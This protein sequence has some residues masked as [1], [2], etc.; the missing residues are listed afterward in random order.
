MR[1]FAPSDPHRSESVIQMRRNQWS[2]Y[3]GITDPLRRNTHEI[4]MHRILESLHD[5]YPFGHDFYFIKT[6]GYVLLYT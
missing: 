6:G 3:F 2:T 1:R 5:I 4:Q